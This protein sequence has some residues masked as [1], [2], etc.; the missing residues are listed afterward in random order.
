MTVILLYIT[1]R[2]SNP[3]H[4]IGRILTVSPWSARMIRHAHRRIVP[5]LALGAVALSGFA[6]AI[7]IRSDRD[8]QQAVDLARPFDMT[9]RVSTDGC[10]TLIAP[11]WVLTAAHVARDISPFATHVQFGDERHA[12]KRIVLHPDTLNAPPGRPPRPDL[13]LL[14]L[15]RPVTGITPAALYRDDNE[16]GRTVMVV[17]YGDFG[18]ADGELTFQDGVRRAATNVIDDT[19]EDLLIFT[20]DA[21]PAGTEMEGMGGPGDSGGPML[22]AAEG[23]TFIAGVSSASMGGRPGHYGTRDAYTRVST[24]SSWIAD[25][26][27]DPP[28]SSIPL[29]QVF[30]VSS[31]PLPDDA[32]GQCM[33]T[34]LTALGQPDDRGIAA[35]STTYRGEQARAERDDQAWATLVRKRAGQCGTLTPLRWTPHPRGGLLVQARSSHDGGIM[36]VRLM[37][38]ERA[39]GLM[40]ID[41]ARD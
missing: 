11:T 10:G 36:T 15:D 7:V 34:L 28:A 32:A 6:H 26:L 37:F 2:W 31:H 19:R 27:A 1:V 18:L 33:K 20:F 22:I 17:G 4:L 30:D 23:H 8:L 5:A 16:M 40:G 9:C 41:I 25:V 39:G 12:I 3:T 21:P 38:N 24:F 35:F 29:D 13:A 14:E